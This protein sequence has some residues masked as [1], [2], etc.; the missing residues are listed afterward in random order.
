MLLLFLLLSL[1]TVQ[2][3][4]ALTSTTAS[5][6]TESFATTT[7]SWQD[8]LLQTAAQPLLSTRLSEASSVLE[9]DG[10][11][12]IGDIS[13]NP[14]R[15][16][17]LRQRILEEV[18]CCKHHI[19]NSI[20]DKNYVP[21]TRLR[22]QSAM[23][24]A[25]GG[26]VRHDLLLPI[27]KD[28]YFS[29]TLLPVLQSATSQLEILLNDGAE[30]LLPRLYKEGQERIPS[31]DKN[32]KK[33]PISFGATSPLEIVE[34]ASLL[35]R[36]GSGHQQIHGDYRRFWSEDKHGDSLLNSLN[37]VEPENHTQKRIG[38]LPPRLVTFVA[39]Q[40]IPSNDHGV[41]GFITGTHNGQ[42]HGLIYDNDACNDIHDLSGNAEASQ[43]QLLQL[44][45][46]GVRT[47]CGFQ[48]GDILVYDASVLHWGS[49]NR[50]PN[51][52][53]CM[54]YFGVSRPGAAEQLS[55]QSQRVTVLNEFEKL[56][57]VLLR[58]LI[59]CI[60]EQKANRDR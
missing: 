42:A 47:T 57:P 37:M 12:R 40:D 26:D 43:Q 22:F 2:A 29:E 16:D 21:G 10:V 41:T 52:H 18:D 6:S 49:A 32:N 44:S 27:C 4:V 9:R 45:T 30:R 56:P 20:S 39:L 46:S 54:L 34:V 7:L 24:L 59:H 28:S 5:T 53:R 15:C 33:Y 36:C 19:D 50:I 8:E 25:F 11:V 23:D 14:D 17:A 58:D 31:K 1:L 48:Q 55:G 51:N 13:I 35:L 60:D 38:K 3:A